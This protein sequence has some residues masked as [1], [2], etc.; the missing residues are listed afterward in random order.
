MINS[1]ESG[2]SVFASSGFN[3]LRFLDLAKSEKI[4][5]YSCVPTMLQAI[6][7]RAEKNKELAKQLNLRFITNTICSYN[8]TNLKSYNSK[9]L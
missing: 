7:L 3:A 8:N 6:L 2:G 1:I 5:W 4:T 9:C